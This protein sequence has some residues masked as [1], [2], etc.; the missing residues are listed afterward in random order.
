MII[1]STHKQ[2]VD[3]FSNEVRALRLGNHHGSHYLSG[4]QKIR[5]VS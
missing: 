1:S 4:E 3:H 2:S 5:R